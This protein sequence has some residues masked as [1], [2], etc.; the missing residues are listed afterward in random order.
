MTK[1]CGGEEEAEVGYDRRVLT[2]V[3][4]HLVEGMKADVFM[5]WMRLIG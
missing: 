4:F 3:L 2:D 5:E 1:A